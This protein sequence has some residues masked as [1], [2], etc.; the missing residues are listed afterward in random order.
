MKI[1]EF[2]FEYKANV[3]RESE[4][5]KKHITTKYVPF[6]EKVTK[7]KHIVDITMTDEKGVFNQ[8]TP[9]RFLTFTMT[10]LTSYTDLEID[11]E[12]IWEEYDKLDEIG[13]LEHINAAI[14][15]NEVNEFNTLLAMT[16]DDYMTNHR[17]I[18]A[19]FDQYMNEIKQQVDAAE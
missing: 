14:P 16:V 11:K 17:S 15:P 18:V 3:G 6:L 12:K 2:I 1:D 9:S 10:M 8:R 4:I 5:C 7:C 19:Y 13:A